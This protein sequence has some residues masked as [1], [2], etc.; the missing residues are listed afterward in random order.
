VDDAEETVTLRRLSDTDLAAGSWAESRLGD[1]DPGGGPAVDAAIGLASLSFITAAIRRRARFWCLAGVLGLLLGAGLY[2]AHPPQVGA[3][4][5]ML[6]E[7]GPNEDLNTAIDTDAAL[8]TS[9]PVAEAALQ[10]LGLNESTSAFLT[11]YTATGV[12][13]RVLQIAVSASSP[14]EAVR[15]A[16]A[17]AQ[18]FMAFRA[19]QLLAYQN[20]TVSSLE[21]EV[22][23]A[24]AR[25]AALQARADELT[26]LTAPTPEQSQELTSLTAQLNNARATL[27][28]LVQAARSTQLTVTSA[29]NT[30]VRGSHIINPGSAVVHSRIKTGIIYAVTGLLGFLVLGIGFVAVSALVSDK[31]RRRDDVAQALGVPVGLSIGRVRPRRARTLAA[32][33]R[34]EIQRIAGHLASLLPDHTAEPDEPAG[35]R[36]A[37]L[38]VVP[39]DRPEIPALAM[40]TLAVARAGQGEQVILADLIPGAPAARL[41]GVKTPGLHQVSADGQQLTVFVAESGTIPPSGPLRPVAEQTAAAELSAAWASSGLLL[42]LV[43]L[44]PMLG[45]GHLVS[46]AP[47]AAVLVT[48]GQSTWTRVQAVGEMIRLGGAQ[49]V[50]A[51]LL[52]A[53]KGDESLGLTHGPADLHGALYEPAAS[54]YSNGLAGNANGRTA[55][56]QGAAPASPGSAAPAPAGTGTAQGPPPAPR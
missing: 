35:H 45:A 52:G 38:A 20:L 21:Q 34:P 47:A 13:N 19:Q 25:V 28:V 14:S 46:W 40:V 18:A 10:K 29:T 3:T 48:T 36:K 7:L 51:I 8:A 9:R 43:H 5:Q 39:A 26:G 54:L 22:S 50:S 12:T 17:L 49:L 11:S 56:A 33:S 53:D 42:T 4:A 55:K 1:P 32:A 15:R 23:A 41:L 30:A 37:A 31:L 16:N 44:D 27:S 2:V 6:L 24:K